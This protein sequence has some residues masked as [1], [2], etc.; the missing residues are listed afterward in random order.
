M[1]EIE[2]KSAHTNGRR[3][4]ISAVGDVADKFLELGKTGL[5]E[6]GGQIFEEFIRELDSPRKYQLFKEMSENSSPVASSLS[7]ILMLTRQA[8][9]RTEAADTSAQAKKDAE[10]LKGAMDDM[11]EPWIDLVDGGM[12]GMLINGWN[13]NELVYKR[14]QGKQPGEDEDGNQLPKSQFKDN[15]IGWRKIPIRHP[16]TLWKWEL[17]NH[18]AIKG[19][20]QQVLFQGGGQVFIP[21]EKL[22]LF[23]T[24]AFK[25]NPEGLSA[26]R[27]A[28][29]SW[30][31]YKQIQK[32]LVI[33]VERDLT[34]LPVMWVDA[35]LFDKDAPARIKE[36]LEKAKEIVR[37]TKR[38]EQEGLVLPSAYDENGNQLV[39]FDL[40]S[41]GGK[42]QFDV[43]NVLKFYRQEIYNTFMANFLIL[44]EDKSGSFSLSSN[45]TKLFAMAV[46]GYMDIFTEV[47][48]RFAVPRLFEINGFQREALPRIEHGD[49]ETKDA[50]ASVDAL[51]KMALAGFEGVG[52]KE[53]VDV[54]LENVGLPASKEPAEL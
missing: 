45:M 39:K 24:T 14:R 7:A 52:T 22:V 23:R 13:A 54:I 43:V 18:G 34:G 17:D 36:S 20:H 15:L 46:G 9:W 49:I 48:N 32:I 21:V 10:F 16:E 53:Q 50:I 38:D 2:T 41:S 35:A 42:R 37:K 12:R 40:I 11:S 30:V 6:Q 4:V 27:P 31:Y 19:L 8:S 47:M 3:E 25:G 44:G 33:G 29:P 51:T 28:Y 5:R 26:L 1:A